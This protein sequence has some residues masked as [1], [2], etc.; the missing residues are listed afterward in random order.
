[1]DSLSYLKKYL[2][3]DKLE[4]GI[5][6]LNAG[7]PVQYIVGN[8]AFFDLEFDVDKNVL[9][10]RFE[11]EELVEK[12]MQY[13]KQNPTSFYRIADIGTGCGCIAITLSKKLPCEVIATDISSS[14][15]EV[16]KKNASKNATSV[17]FL[18]G[19]LLEPL[20]GQFDC[21]ISNPPYISYEEEIMDIVKNNEPSIAL[22]A[23][24]DG[25]YFYEEI[26][27][28]VRP[29]LKDKAFLAFEIGQTQGE[30]ISSLAHQYFPNCRTSVEKDLT[31]VDRFFFLFYENFV[32]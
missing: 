31:G 7:E 32:E 25:L 2:P 12:T 27:K 9:I 17:T 26:L 5:K 20:T 28:Q 29:Y 13:L 3:K 4:E 18:E 22:Y 30:R 6:R 1:M 11:T 10:P 8:V 19:N 15:L 21:I 23:K 16:A 14:A 24:N